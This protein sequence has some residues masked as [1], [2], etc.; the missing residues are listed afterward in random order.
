MLA[1]PTRG[2]ESSV[3]SLTVVAGAAPA[4]SNATAAAAAPDVKFVNWTVQQFDSGIFF[5]YMTGCI[6][7]H[8]VFVHTVKLKQMV[9][10]DWLQHKFTIKFDKFKQGQ[11]S[12]AI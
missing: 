12:A 4:G 5:P 11:L 10:V 3:S 2:A 8:V 7:G 1:R 9:Q 6:S